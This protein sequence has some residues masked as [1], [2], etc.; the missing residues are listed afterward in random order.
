MRMGHRFSFNIDKYFADKDRPI[1]ALGGTYPAAHHVRPHTHPRGQL[2]CPLSGVVTA[3]TAHGTW[4]VPAMRG[5]WIP[6]GVQHELRMQGVVEMH[7]LYFEPSSVVDLPSRCQVVGISPLMR[8]L[9]DEAV[10]LPVLYEREA[11]PA[12]SCSS[13]A[14]K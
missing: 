14:L 5:L 11:D 10:A 2:F 4:A 3:T 8:N 9:I 7:S 6:A 13:S 12:R 1:L